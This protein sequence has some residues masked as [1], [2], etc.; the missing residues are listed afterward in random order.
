MTTAPAQVPASRP[1]SPVGKGGQG[2]RTIDPKYLIV[3]L[4]TLV[5]VVGEARYSILGGYNRLATTLGLCLV[6]EAWLSWWL[7]GRVVNLASAYI[8]GIS[9]ALLTKPQANILWPFALGAFLAIASKYVLTYRNRHLWNPSNFAISYLVLAAPSSVA[10]LS[11]QWGNDLR[12]NLVIWAFG[13][14]IA[15]RARVLHVTLT[16]VACFVVLAIVRNLIVGGPLLA[17]LAP[18]TGPMYQ[19]FVFFMVTDPRTTV[20]TRR[21]RMI[22]VAIVALVESIIRISGDFQ[23]ALLRPFYVSPPILA[24]AIVGPIAMWWDL[25]R[26]AKRAQ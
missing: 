25:H 16:Y 11:H 5:L 12:I 24:L 10:I 21:G 22:V 18:I 26:T 3:F 6:T 20:S 2:L 17:E 7:R 4:I 14:I 19:L 13:L 1:P 15:S 8:T 9:L 23:L